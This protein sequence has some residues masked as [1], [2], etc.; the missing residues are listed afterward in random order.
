M[1]RYS[2]EEVQRVDAVASADLGRIT[3][4]VDT[5]GCFFL[6][7]ES[8]GVYVELLHPVS[9]S[10]E[11]GEQCFIEWVGS[12][13][14]PSVISVS[15][16]YSSGQSAVWETLAEGLPLSG[17]WFWH[18]EGL[19][20][21][22]YWLRL[23]A[24]GP[25][26]VLAEDTIGPVQLVPF[27]GSIICAPNPAGSHGVVFYYELNPE[28]DDAELVILDIVGSP[29]FRTELETD[30]A[31]FPSAGSWSLVTDTGEQ[32]A[33]GPYVYVLIAGGRVIGQGKMVIQR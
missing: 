18:T 4:T 26:G 30:S 13:D 3:A 28:A 33:N 17:E 21:G 25:L 27:S 12:A 11:A 16:E 29:V 6:G 9:E 32:L 22:Q 2:S 1:Y 23:K 20:G 8:L 7:S 15:L 31:R 10:L 24:E 19:D 14:D 5:L